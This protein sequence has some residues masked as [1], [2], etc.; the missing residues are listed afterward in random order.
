MKESNRDESQ[1]GSITESQPMLDEC[2]IQALLRFFD[3][4]KRWDDESKT[5]N[6]DAA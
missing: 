2:S 3:L 1:N 5:R 6:H 4:L